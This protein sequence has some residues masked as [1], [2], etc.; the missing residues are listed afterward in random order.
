MGAQAVLERET[1]EII[2]RKVIVR[3]DKRIL[4]RVGIYFPVDLAIE[5]ETHCAKKQVDM[6]KWVSK[7]VGERLSSGS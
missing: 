2:P 6:S 1:A 5:I 7:V 3:K 4:K